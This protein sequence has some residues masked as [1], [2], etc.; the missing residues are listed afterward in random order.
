MRIFMVRCKCD[1]VMGMNVVQEDILSFGMQDKA[2]A[3]D[4]IGPLSQGAQNRPQTLL[5]K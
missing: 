4:P 5:D 2:R 3:L 1:R